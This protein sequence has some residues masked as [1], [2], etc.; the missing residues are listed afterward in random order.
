MTHQEQA[1]Q[2]LSETLEKLATASRDPLVAAAAASYIK[3][4]TV[5]VEEAITAVH[6]SCSGTWVV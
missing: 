1:L 3:T 2:S 6:E 5:L 4:A